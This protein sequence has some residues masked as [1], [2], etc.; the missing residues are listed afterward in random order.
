VSK[1][2]AHRLVNRYG[3]AADQVA[4]G[5]MGEMFDET[6]SEAEIPYLRDHEWANSAQSM[7][8]RRTKTNLLASPESLERIHVAISAAL[9]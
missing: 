9:R 4:S 1:G 7:L 3:L 5:D 2:Y 6:F 8:Q